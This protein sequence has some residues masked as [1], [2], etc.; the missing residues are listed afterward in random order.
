MKAKNRIMQKNNK[1]AELPLPPGP[2][3]WTGIQDY[4]QGP[5]QYFEKL[6]Q[7]YGDVVRWRG[8]FTLYTI[9][10]PDYV[11]QILTQDYPRFIK[12][13]IDYRVIAQSLGKGL[14]TSEG[15]FWQQQ[16]KL[17]QPIFTNRN[18]NGFDT[19][20]NAMTAQMLQRW[21]QRSP[22]TTIWL[23]REMGHVAFQIVSRALF[24][25]DIDHCSDEIVE[26]LKVINT[27]SQTL[28]AMLRLLPWLPVPS[29][30][31]FLRTKNQLDQIVYGL[32]ERRRK[33][34]VGNN[35]MLD[36][37]LAAQDAETGKG[38]S[39]IQL[40]DEIVTLLLA[41]HET[42]GT[43]IAWT[44]YLLSQHSQIEAQLVAELDSVLSGTP[45]TS[46]DLARLP[47]LKQ[48]M[49]ESLR[50]YPPIWAIARQ[51]TE[52]LELGG[53]RIPPKSYL[54]M[55]IYSLHRH[56]D[57]W[58]DP[59]KFDPDRFAPQREASRHS[60]CYLPFSAGPRTCIG[61]NMAMLEIQ[62]VLA[63][64]LQRFRVT[65]VAGHPV[66]PVAEITFKPRYGLAVRV[67]AR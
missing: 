40:R 50:L 7:T 60:Y 51:N 5:P 17:M 62:L 55:P 25:A 47:Y 18:V 11:R 20:I 38:M 49:Q 22:A 16:R 21:E 29:N 24:G 54:V 65:P 37:L 9:N 8:M 4:W 41:G 56:P 31:H 33:Q 3:L 19:I 10:N 34:G 36:R 6:A 28:R 13:T 42:T 12:D 59:E 1:K 53:Y 44:L 30:R 64:V 35:D 2:P 39:E 15:A 48:V 43:A 66:E 32:I 14:V 57:Y 26:I 63:Q 27:N 67:E 45:A 52:P 23:D 58:P 61:A 46:G